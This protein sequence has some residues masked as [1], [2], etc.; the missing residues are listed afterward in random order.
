MENFI[1]N[2]LKTNTSG[3][4]PKGNSLPS[5]FLPGSTPAPVPTK[6]SSPNMSYAKDSTATR[7]T[8]S[9]ASPSATS[10]V[11]TK[12]TAPSSSFEVVKKLQSDLNSKNQGVAGYTPL[13]VD[14]ILGDKTKAAMS[15]VPQDQTSG[16]TPP[17]GGSTSTSG[18]STPPATTTPSSKDN[19]TSAYTS[20]I[21]SLKNTKNV[22]AAK[23]AYNDYVANQTKSIAAKEGQGRGIPLA[24]VRGEQEK[25]LR[26]TQ[27][28][29]LRLQNEIGIA[30]DENKA[31][32]D[33]EKAN[34]EFRGALLEED[35]PIEVNGM[36][37]QKQPDGSYK[38]ITSKPAEGFTLG[39][40]Q[41][42]YDA[43]GKVV[44]G[45]GSST[46]TPSGAYVEGANPTIDSYIKAIKNNTYKIGDVPDQYKDA[47]TQGLTAKSNQ[48]SD[49]SKNVLSILDTLLANPKLSGISGAL[50]QFTGGLSGQSALAKNYYNQ[51]QGILKLENRQQLKGSGAISDFEFK[52]L[53]EASSALGRNLSDAD[54]KNELQKLKDKLTGNSPIPTTPTDGDVW[55][56]PDRTEYEY[57]NGYWQPTNQSFNS[58]GN[59]TVSIPSSSR[60]AKVNNNPGNLRYAG[61]AGATQG[62][63]GFAKFK[64]P[65]AGIQALHDQIALDASRGLTLAQFI[66]K[67][68]PP[69]ENDTAKY[70]QDI[71]TATGASPAT[72]LKNI[73]ITNLTKAVALKE[74]S[75]KIG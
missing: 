18:G 72:L 5:Y 3:Y 1:N 9:P 7:P 48:L 24:L 71:I 62:E 23:T 61:Q 6:S 38:A 74:S 20:Y 52:V 45:G 12:T 42:R 29:A 51:L 30:Q 59:T 21:D 25:L 68:A 32:T 8:S 40:D 14:G 26:Q 46:G 63:G 43:E 64:T 10:S 22:S 50:D 36:L 16:T 47:V 15:F 65:E 60:L 69:S 37:Y 67:Y 41:V 55:K 66:S 31:I 35:K 4:K 53:G 73:D 28:E 11:P 33:A 75:T 58:V 13:V 39:K 19:Y 27:P 56:A 17:T 70:I 2:L 34:V 44:A 49:S 57:K 54:F